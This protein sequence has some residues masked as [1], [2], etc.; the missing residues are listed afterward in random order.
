MSNKSKVLYVDDEPINLT[1]FKAN[2]KNKFTII[3]AE[4]GHQGLRQLKD[5]PDTKVVISDMKMP[6]MSGID[7]IRIAKKEYP[8]ITFYILTGYDI[9]D[10][11]SQALKDHLIR[12]YFRKPFNIN[13]IETAILEAVG[14]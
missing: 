5:N 4:C 2:F 12:K 7:F 14:M 11:I 6:G 10:E 9:T 3:T 1:L 13:E 8:N